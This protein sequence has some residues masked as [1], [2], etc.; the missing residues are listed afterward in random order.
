MMFQAVPLF[1]SM[2]SPLDVVTLPVLV[3]VSGLLAA[4]KL[5]FPVCA[6][7]IVKP[8]VALTVKLS[9][10]AAELGPPATACV[11][12]RVSAP[13]AKGAVGV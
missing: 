4:A 8:P 9:V 1:P 7:L 6:V 11:A 10:A 2:A 12:V 5:T 13:L 3:I